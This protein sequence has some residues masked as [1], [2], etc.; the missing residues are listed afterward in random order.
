VTAGQARIVE[1]VPHEPRLDPRIAWV[2]ALCAEIAPTEVYAAVWERASPSREYDGRVYVERVPV[3][4]YA[5]VRAKSVAAALGALGA[6]GPGRR[7]AERALQ[8]ETDVDGADGSLDHHVGALV[9]LLTFSGYGQLIANALVRRTRALSIPP[10]VVV[11]H[12][13]PALP[14]ALALKELFGSRVV[15]DAHEL[16]PEADLLAPA[17]ERRTLT[18]LER[19]LIRRAD[20]VVTVSPPLARAFEGLFGIEGVVAA[21]NAVPFSEVTSRPP[22]RAA[23]HPVHFLLQGQLAARRGIET[24]LEGW[25]SVDASRAVLQIR[26]PE[27][28]FKEHLRRDLAGELERGAVE[29]PEPVAE[30]ELVEAAAASDVGVI[31]YPAGSAIHDFACP[32]KLSEYMHAGLAIMSTNLDYVGSVLN[33]FDCGVTYETGDPASV[34]ATVNALV[35]DLPRLDRLRQNAFAAGRDEFNWERQSAEYRA[36]LTRL[37]F[38]RRAA[39]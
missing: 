36:L 25:R 17:W 23:R 4:E 14:A 33:R 39:A 7:Y 12:D 11:C 5:S 10:A 18:R 20:G 16:S 27:S 9:R 37:L 31:P 13:L 1:L 26:A 2:T 15:Y 29:L 19:R 34:S 21:P 28:P 32:N 3:G 30:T 6:T 24:L 38:E 22:E 8:P 35:E